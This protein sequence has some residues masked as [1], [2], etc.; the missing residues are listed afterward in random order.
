MVLVLRLSSRTARLCFSDK[1]IQ[2]VRPAL[3]LFVLLCCPTSSVAQQPPEVIWP[4][5]SYAEGA[6]VWQTEPGY[7]YRMERSRDLQTWHQL[8]GSF[9]GLGQ[10]VTQQLHEPLLSSAFPGGPP[11]TPPAVAAPVT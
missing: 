9:Y 8:P 4:Y 6:V 3:A 10:S 2:F 11:A 7:L 5:E 1:F